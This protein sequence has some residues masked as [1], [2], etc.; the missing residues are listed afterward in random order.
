MFAKMTVCSV[1]TVIV[2]LYSQDVMYRWQQ[3]LPKGLAQYFKSDS[4]RH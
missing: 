3:C 2:R 4:K 1:I